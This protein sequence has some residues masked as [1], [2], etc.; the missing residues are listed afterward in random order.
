MR[1]LRELIA[2]LAEIPTVS[3]FEA[4]NAEEFLQL[5]LAEAGGFF[6]EGEILPSGSLLLARK[7]G[8]PGAKKLVFDAHCDTVGFVVKAH[9]DGGFVKVAPIGGMDPYILPS[10]AVMLYGKRAVRGFFTSVPPHLAGKGEKEIR[11]DDLYVD[12]GLGD[13]E[14]REVLPIGTPAGFVAGTAGLLGSVI[15]S[16]SLDDKACCAAV[17]LAARLLSERAD[18]LAVD[19]YA[20]FAAGEERTQLGAKG[21]PFLLDADA[22]VVL[23]VNFAVAPGVEKKEALVQGAGPGVSYSVSVK[24]ALTDFLVETAQKNGIPVQSVVE[25]CSTGTN[26]TLIHKRG[27]AGAVLS[28]P[29]RNMHTTCETVDLADVENMA[30][31]IAALALD[32]ENAPEAVEVIK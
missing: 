20:H 17:I 6:T 15:T 11:V 21:L 3:G 28:I 5:A 14:L 26:A 19:V 7:T 9:F 16:P 18:D 25:M 1:E 24:R 30:A 22:C 13:E 23:D 32:F 27:L 2:A 8:V 12:T 10:S 4:R 29:L 31:L